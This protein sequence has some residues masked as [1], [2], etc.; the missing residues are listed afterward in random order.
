M[1]TSRTRPDVGSA[2]SVNVTAGAT[3]T[4]NASLAQSGSIAG[5][6]TAADGTTP[7][8]NIQATA[9]R[10]N[11]GTW[12]S[13]SS[14][15]TDSAGQ[16]DISGLTAGTYRVGFSDSSGNYLE[17]Y[18]DNKPDVDSATDVAVTP[19]PRPLHNASLAPGR[20]HRRQGDGGRRHDA[21][22]QH[23]GHGLPAERRALG[24]QCAPIT[25][26]APA[27]MTSTA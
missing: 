5:K 6:V 21:A 16:Y 8:A 3:T 9:Y 15:S 22:G 14:D 7:L 1:S 11:G 4:V 18:Y 2:T 27:S 25:P 13:V 24:N 10:L 20:P 26:T 23:P 12:Q 19:G 17:E